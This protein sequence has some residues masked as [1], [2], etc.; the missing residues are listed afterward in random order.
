MEPLAITNGNRSGL[1]GVLLDGFPVYGPDDI[2]GRTPTGLDVCNGH[3]AATED[4]PEGIYHYH[5]TATTPYI[6][7]C[8]RGTAGS[9]G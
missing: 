1:I 4:A 5:T 6:S 2:G 9:V 3:T 7:G 8:F